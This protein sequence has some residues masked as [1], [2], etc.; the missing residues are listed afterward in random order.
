MVRLQHLQRLLILII[1]L[2]AGNCKKEM[3][4]KLFHSQNKMVSSGDTLPTEIQ[5]GDVA[6]MYAWFDATDAG[7]ITVSSGLVDQLSDKS[8]NARHLIS[9][10]GN[11]PNYNATGGANNLPYISFASG[12][13]LQKTSLTL[14][15]P[16]TIL[17][18]VKY[19][20]TPTINANIV[21][22]GS[23][24][25]LLWA[26]SSITGLG[27]RY[28][29]NLYGGSAS[30]PSLPTQF[31]PSTWHTLKS[32]Y[33]IADADHD[34]WVNLES[35]I[36][37]TGNIGS[38]GLTEITLGSSV[39]DVQEL[40]IYS[41]KLTENQLEGLT[42]YFFNKY[43]LSRA[44]YMI[45]FGDS[46]TLGVMS[47]QV[48]SAPYLFQFESD[49][50]L[51]CYNIGVSGSVVQS[52]GGTGLQDLYTNYFRYK[53]SKTKVH[54]QYGTNDAANGYTSSAN[55][56]TWKALYKGIIQDFLDE[57]F[58]ASNLYILTPPYSTASYVAGNLDEAVTAIQ[59]IAS[60]LGI[61]LIDNYNA[62]LSAGLNITSTPDQIHPNDA[63]SD[64]MRETFITGY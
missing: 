54:F 57:G 4:I 48:S 17:A 8:G 33:A 42:T 14:A 24:N 63:I 22:L 37:A 12:K 15:Q 55:V 47:G 61:N 7:N 39:Y 6:G 60:E 32:V 58:L 49:L 34:I 29:I 26:S 23:G 11:R 3:S 56:A 43:N 40:I 36:K 18:M 20:A 21:N 25:G 13:F 38:T 41:G 16:L 64:K 50:N 31:R 2:L 59:E 1:P 5:P 53:S 19:S 27:T 62:C 35:K 52:G 51:P 46:I 30:L 10:G 44:D 9:S 45:C 28:Y